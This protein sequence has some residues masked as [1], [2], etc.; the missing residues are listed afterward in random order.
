MTTR[1]SP[2]NSSSRALALYTIAALTLAVPAAAD[3]LTAA[4]GS[5]G[6]ATHTPS[7]PSD[8]A[9][10]DL[11]ACERGD[12]AAC[13]RMSERLHGGDGVARDN[14]RSVAFVRLAC[15]QENARACYDLGVRHILGEY[16]VQ[17]F[18]EALRW[19]MHSCDLDSGV[20]CYFAATLMR[21]GVG[22]PSELDASD[23]LMRR[24]CGLGY[25]DA[26]AEAGSPRVTVGDEVARLPADAPEE[27][28]SLA[29]ACD[30]GLMGACA[31][32]ANV[33]DTGA[34]LARDSD[35]SRTLRISA[36]DWGLLRACRALGRD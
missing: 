2:S 24:A 6:L 21:D 20:A 27:L 23:L 17:D 4:D 5:E 10:I 15:D 36:C 3:T 26:C 13:Y 19:I 16:V 31:D 14:P 22:I 30:A 7:V 33:W 29:G 28:V 9:S 1:D 8:E 35:H 11:A 25:L 34:D 32:L 12:S 18:N